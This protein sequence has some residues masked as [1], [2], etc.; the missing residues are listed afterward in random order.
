MATGSTT[1]KKPVASPYVSERREIIHYKEFRDRGIEIGSGPT[2]S[3][4]K[5]TALRL[6]GRGRR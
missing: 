6:R 3:Q 5:T 2:E 1:A 4:C